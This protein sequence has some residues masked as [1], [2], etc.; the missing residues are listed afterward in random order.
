MEMAGTFQLDENRLE[1]D[2]SVLAQINQQLL[3]DTQVLQNMLN[4]VRNAWVSSGNDA[5]SF[6]DLLQHNINQINEGVIP[7]LSA[8]VETCN[9]LAANTRVAKSQTF[10]G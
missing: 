9:T 10:Q 2:A 4:I 8:F 5:A 6:A 3:S 1:A 7:T